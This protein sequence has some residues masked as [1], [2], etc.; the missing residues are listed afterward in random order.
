MRCA[1]LVTFLVLICSCNRAETSSAPPA[2]P[3]EANV[4]VEDVRMTVERSGDRLD[5]CLCHP[6]FGEL[7]WELME[8]VTDG[9]LEFLD[10]LVERRLHRW[11]LQRR[12]P[13]LP[14][15]VAGGDNPRKSLSAAALGT[16]GPST[17]SHTLPTMLSAPL[18]WC[19][20]SGQPP[21][22]RHS[23]RSSGPA[24]R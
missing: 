21:S 5:V 2:G 16:T 11:T 4:A 3:G 13:P 15:A 23:L 24:A 1:Y 19:R 20:C 9:L 10:R 14:V 12:T 17:N 22:V 6:I 7:D 8:V 18:T